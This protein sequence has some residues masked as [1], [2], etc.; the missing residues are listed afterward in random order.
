[1]TKVKCGLCK[2]IVPVKM[3]VL[4]MP[5]LSVHKCLSK[6]EILKK[7]KQKQILVLYFHYIYILTILNNTMDK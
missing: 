2:K 5:V 4:G 1:M 3:F 7:Y 6:E